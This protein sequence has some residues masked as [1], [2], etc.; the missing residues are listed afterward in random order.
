MA[1]VKEFLSQAPSK[2]LH[3]TVSKN[4]LRKEKFTMKN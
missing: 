1:R 3:T 2:I 4:R